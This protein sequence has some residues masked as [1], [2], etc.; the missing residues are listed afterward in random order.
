M[1]HQI[2]IPGLMLPADE[3]AAIETLRGL[4]VRYVLI[5]NRP[6]REFGAEAF[7]RDFYQDLGRFVEDNYRLIKVCGESIRTNPQIGDPGFFIKI[8]ELMKSRK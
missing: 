1:R 7:G 5:V 3:I 8:Y 4:P 6:M 2:L